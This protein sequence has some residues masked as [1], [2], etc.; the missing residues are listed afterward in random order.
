MRRTSGRLAVTLVLAILGFLVVVQLRVQSTAPGL[1]GLS[2]QDLTVLIANLTTGNALL[3]DEVETLERQE[4]AL[5]AGQDRGQTSLGQIRA[6]LSRVRAFAGA[7]GVTGDGV[8]VRVAGPLPADAVGMLL[9]E[10]R[11]A[12]AEALTVGEVRVVPGVG[13]SGRAGQ[14]EVGGRALGDPFELLAIGSP[15]T[16]TGSLTRAGG[17][18][19]QLAATFPSVFVEVVPEEDLTLPPAEGPLAPR[20]GRPR[21]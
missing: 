11:N 15:E 9:N 14:L 10:L 6:D 1:Q 19:A 17:P 18:I 16:L 3:A 13:I 21:V 12:G 7:V 8:R 2:T 20:Y 4:A 5:A